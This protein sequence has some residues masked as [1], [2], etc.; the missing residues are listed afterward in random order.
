M[1][2]QRR[3]RRSTTKVIN[4]AKEQE[5][6]DEDIF[7][8]SPNEDPP[9]PKRGRGRPRKDSYLPIEGEDAMTTDDE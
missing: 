9:E 4:Y 5:F 3:S 7:E 8:D 1:P 6:S 2:E